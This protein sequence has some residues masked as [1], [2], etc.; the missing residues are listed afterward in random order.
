M[1]TT[2]RS[3][4]A[5]LPPSS[6]PAATRA[7]GAD[8]AQVYDVRLPP[9]GVTPR[10]VTVLVVHGGFWRA[11]YDRAHAEPEAQA[12]AGAGY[13]VAVAEYRRVGMPGGGVPGT[14]D[15]VRGLVTAVLADPELPQPIVLVGHSAGGHLV[16]WAAAQPWLTEGHPGAVAGVVSLAGV[17]D[18]GAADRMQLGDGAARAFVGSDAGSAA[19]AEADPMSTQ[20]SVPV[21]LIWGDAD[22]V[23]PTSVGDAYLAKARAAGADVTS[24]VIAGADH[25]ALID[26][27]A[28]AFRSVLAAVHSLTPTTP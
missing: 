10:H 16:T 5:P 28:P 18:L 17:V 27:T 3:E 26:P 25:F 20:P 22:D 14:L 8:P 15:D 19:W 4:P 12:F 23:V 13:T 6:P 7:Y 2:P 9:A 21:R 11:A 24:E 1:S